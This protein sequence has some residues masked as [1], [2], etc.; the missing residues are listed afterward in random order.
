MVDFEY[1]CFIDDA[2]CVDNNKV[3]VISGYLSF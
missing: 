2:N 1:F 3:K